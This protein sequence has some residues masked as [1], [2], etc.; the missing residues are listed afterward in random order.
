M[1]RKAMIDSLPALTERM[2]ARP[3]ESINQRLV[4]VAAG[5]IKAEGV[6]KRDPGGRV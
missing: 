4:D 2:V 3:G 5:A 1:S 6:E